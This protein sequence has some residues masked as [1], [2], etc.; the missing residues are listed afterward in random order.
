M[1]HYTESGLT[2]VWLL[3]GFNIRKTD[4][5][6]FV[7]F[8]DADELHRVIGRALT[9]KPRLTGAEFRYL[10]KELGLSQN[11][12]GEMIGASEE[13]ISLW[14]RKGR[15]SKGYDQ[16]MRFLYLGKIDGDARISELINQFVELDKQESEKLLFED[17]NCG[18]KKAA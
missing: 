13:S 1:Y 18:W 16:L 7:S 12:L 3:N 4:A 17:T 5:G 15:I 14:E 6:E 2:N 10:R 8:T 9:R 11:K